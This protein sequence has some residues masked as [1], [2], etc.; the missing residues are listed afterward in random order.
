MHH[1]DTV[2]LDYTMRSIILPILATVIGTAILQTD[3][4]APPMPVDE[5]RNDIDRRQDSTECN[6]PWA[7]AHCGL[8]DWMQV[9]VGHGQA[10]LGYR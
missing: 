10:L 1:R 5:I 7:A 8:H 2:L 9:H 4:R 6:T 3:L